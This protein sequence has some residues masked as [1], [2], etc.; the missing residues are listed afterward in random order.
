MNK[1]ITKSNSCKIRERETL[2]AN[3]LGPPYLIKVS[4]G[5]RNFERGGGAPE[6]GGS[7]PE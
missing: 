4:G 5:I 1:Y 2:C 7:S 3:E 6:R